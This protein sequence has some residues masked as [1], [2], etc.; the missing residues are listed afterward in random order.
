MPY[1]D[2][3]PGRQGGRDRIRG[4]HGSDASAERAYFTTITAA[5]HVPLAAELSRDD[6]NFVMDAITASSTLAHHI[7]TETISRSQI[8]RTYSQTDTT[9]RVFG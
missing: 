8:F 3:F 7:T 5:R 2:A 1:G 9:T 4:N 6:Y